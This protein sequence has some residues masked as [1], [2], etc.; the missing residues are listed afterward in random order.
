[1]ESNRSE[2]VEF[3]QPQQIDERVAIASACSLGLRLTVPILVD[4]ADNAA[5]RA[6][7]AWPERIYVIDTAGRIAYQGGKGP[8]GFDPEELNRFL[9]G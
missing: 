5:D 8:Y 9:A 6:F 2:G 4:T 7:Q 3:A 1:M